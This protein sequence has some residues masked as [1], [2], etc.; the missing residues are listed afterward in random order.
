MR[1]INAV[2]NVNGVERK[3]E[4]EPGARD[5]ESLMMMMALSS[6][7]EQFYGTCASAAAVHV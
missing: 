5:T 2:V 4:R 7:R 1:I 6:F 3:K